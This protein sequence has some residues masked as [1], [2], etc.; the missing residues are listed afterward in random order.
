MD[1][2]TIDGVAYKLDSLSENAKQ[3]LA[4]MQATDMEIQRLNIQ[5]AI[6]Q[7]ARTGYAAAL[8]AE[9]PQVKQ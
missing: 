3:Q 2:V 4:M 8:N 1:E 6:A 5:M 9:L 7:T